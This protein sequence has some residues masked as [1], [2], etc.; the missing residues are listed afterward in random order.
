MIRGFTVYANPLDY[1]GLIVVR[2]WRIEAGRV[3]P[4]AAPLYVGRDLAEARAALLAL[5]PGLVRLPRD[6]TDDAAI[7]E[8]WI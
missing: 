2:G 5:D 6:R 8:S 7:L 3:V 1:P 4:E